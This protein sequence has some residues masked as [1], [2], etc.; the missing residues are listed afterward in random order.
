MTAAAVLKPRWGQPLT[1][2]ISF[3]S[4]WYWQWPYSLFLNDPRGP[5]KWFPYP[6][7]MYLAMMILVGLYQHM[8]LGDWPFEK[9]SQPTRGIVETIVNIGLVWFIIHIVF[10]KIF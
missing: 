9:L 3:F 7:V 4:F 5:V 10:Y 1:G 8:F 2:I 6:F